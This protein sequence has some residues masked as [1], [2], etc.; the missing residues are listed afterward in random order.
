MLTKILL[1]IENPGINPVLFFMGVKSGLMSV[2]MILPFAQLLL[3]IFVLE[4]PLRFMTIML[5]IL[6]YLIFSF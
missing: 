5:F 2:M 6:F 3:K 4:Y 1:R